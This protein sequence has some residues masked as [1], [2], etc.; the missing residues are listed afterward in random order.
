MSDNMKPGENE[1]E[2]RKRLAHPPCRILL[3]SDFSEECDDEVA[4]ELLVRKLGGLESSFTIEILLP[5]AVERLLW[6]RHIF[7]QHFHSGEWKWV[8]DDASPSACQFVAGASKNVTVRIYCTEGPNKDKVASK[9]PKKV[10][11]T[12]SF[13]VPRAAVPDHTVIPQADPLHYIVWNAAVPVTVLPSW[14][15][16][17][18]N[19][20]EAGPR[21]G[22]APYDDGVVRVLQIGGDGSINSK[23]ADHFQAILRAL[24]G[25][26]VGTAPAAA[27]SAAA[28]SPCAPRLTRVL[29]FLKELTRAVRL[30]RGLA[31]ELPAPI[32]Q[33]VYSTFVK[34][35][36][37]R[38]EFPGGAKLLLRLNG[39]NAAMCRDWRAVALGAGAPSVL[40]PEHEAK[41]KQWAGLYVNRWCAGASNDERAALEAAVCECVTTSMELLCHG[42]D[43][44]PLRLWANPAASL[45]ELRDP[46][47]CVRTARHGDLLQRVERLTPA[48]DCVSVVAMLRH[49]TGT[50]AQGAA[51]PVWAG[52][53]LGAL[54]SYGTGGYIQTAPEQPQRVVDSFTTTIHD[55]MCG[56]DE[57]SDEESD[58]TSDEEVEDFPFK[59]LSKKFKKS[60]EWI[61]AAPPPPPQCRPATALNSTVGES[62]TPPAH[63]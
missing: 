57:E 26:Q 10:L 1:E 42:T 3:I 52:L 36:A 21:G 24:G 48:Y 44:D 49:I 40:A 11:E 59:I 61:W 39:M 9:I 18:H 54:Q 63:G 13:P 15:A 45:A 22:R 47:A 17:F 51:A 25:A 5:D 29:M 62:P 60:D 50:G 27:A 23:P 16:G 35:M 33:A 53:G 6:F 20:A 37:Q 34:F 32:Q 55:F 2:M 30:T 8:K 4:F 46:Q 7:H 19:N 38:P 31:N 12:Q 41:A 56:T 28:A 43:Q 14:F 58:K